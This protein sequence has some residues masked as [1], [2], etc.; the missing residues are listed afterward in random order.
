V[1]ETTGVDDRSWLDVY[2]NPHS[3]EMRVEERYTRLEH[4]HLK[5]AVSVDDSKAYTKLFSPSRD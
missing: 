3:V 1:V 4:G 2:G 5:L